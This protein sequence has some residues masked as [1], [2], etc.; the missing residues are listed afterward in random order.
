MSSGNDERASAELDPPLRP[1]AVFLSSRGAVQRVSI[2]VRSRAGVGREGKFEIVNSVYRLRQSTC[3]LESNGALG[4]TTCHDPHDIRHGED[5]VDRYNKACAGCH[6]PRTIAVKQHPSDR[7][8]V[9]CHMPK[10]R[11]EDV[12]HAVMT[13]HL[14]QRR[15]AGKSF[16][17]V[18]ERHGPQLS[19]AAKSCHM[20]TRTTS[21]Q[22]SRR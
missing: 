2:L 17:G 22:L 6:K 16:G 5:G 13:D 21:T 4:C 11:A 20:E 1:R 12:V 10:R 7:N 9:G 15:P 3:F 8:C 18:S 14:I 19:I